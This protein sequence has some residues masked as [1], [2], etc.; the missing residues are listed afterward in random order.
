MRHDQRGQGIRLIQSAGYLVEVIA[1]TTD[2]SKQFGRDI[3]NAPF[4]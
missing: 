3:R 1:D 2:L 4:T